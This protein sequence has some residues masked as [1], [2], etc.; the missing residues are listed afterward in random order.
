M[1][2]RTRNVTGHIVDTINELNVISVSTLILNET[3]RWCGCGAPLFFR[4]LTENCWDVKLNRCAI[5]LVRDCSVICLSCEPS[6][7]ERLNVGSD[8]TG[9]RRFRIILVSLF[10]LLLSFL[11]KFLPP[12]F[13]LLLLTLFMLRKSVVF[14]VDALPLEL[15]ET[16][17]F[18]ND[19]IVIRTLQEGHVPACWIH[20]ETQPLWN[21]WPHSVATIASSS[22]NSIQMLQSN[23]IS[24][25]DAE[26]SA[27]FVFPTLTVLIVRFC[28]SGAVLIVRFC[29]NEA[30]LIVRFCDS[31]TVLFVRFDGNYVI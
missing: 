16:N 13:L 25:L 19:A 24:L 27:V 3:Y 10:R 29:D 22:F 20:G 14:D 12:L 26:S 6:Q 1:N 2:S 15:T 30:V 18:R 9:V 31:E 5:M 23:A 7:I 28:D 17:I 8:V 21:R 11:V 4:L